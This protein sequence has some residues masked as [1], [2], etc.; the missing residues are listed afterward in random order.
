MKSLLKAEQHSKHYLEQQQMSSTSK[1]HVFVSSKARDMLFEHARFLAQV[2]VQAAEKLFDQFEAR[3]SSLETMPERCAYYDNPFIQP[4][5]YRK[6]SL[7]NNLLILF[8]LIDNTVYVE[9][10]IDGRTESKPLVD[11]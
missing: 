5:K 4:S 7:G 8:Q 11:I 9:I 6:L 2:N 1:Y 10:I 3:V